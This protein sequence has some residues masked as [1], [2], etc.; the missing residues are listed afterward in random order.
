MTYKQRC[1]DM[2]HKTALRSLALL[3]VLATALCVAGCGVNQE[4]TE[5]DYE[6]F[7]N[8]TW[9]PV[10]VEEI[11]AIVT[12]D[13]IANL[14]KY[15]GLKKVDLSGSTCYA[16][17]LAYME[18]HPDVEVTYTVSLGGVFVSTQSTDLILLPGTYD[19][20][21]M[22]ENLAYLPEVTNI[23][24]QRTQL[25][26]EQMAALSEAYPEITVTYSIEFNGVEYGEGTTELNMADFDTAQLSTAM[27]K[28]AMM[29][30]ITYVE[31]MKED[32]T[33]NYTL[34]Q[35]KQL[36]KAAPHIAFN[37]NV[38]FFGKTVST[39]DDIVDF[40]DCDVDDE[41][42]LRSAMELLSSASKVR[43]IGSDLSH[44]TLAAIQ[45]DY[46][47]TKLVWRV[48][49]AGTP[50]LTDE[51]TLFMSQMSLRDSNVENLKYLTS[52]KYVDAGHSEKLTDISWLAYM[53]DVE[54]LILSGSPI[55]DISV[56][57]NCQKI[58]WLELTFCG[59]LKDISVVE[60][61]PTLKYLNIGYTDVS[62]ISALADLSLERFHALSTEVS[63]A[64][65]QAF[66]EA[67]PD[68]WTT[69][70]GS[71]QPYGKGWRY[72]DNGKTYFEY[73]AN[74]REIFDYASR[75]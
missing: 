24:L 72:D 57:S 31:L 49:V 29:D 2:T 28:L 60:N 62:D 36:Q 25:S 51:E 69:Y 27:E 42:E 18:S 70:Y 44:E 32:G 30:Q 41:D 1:T 38:A 43:V 65:F 47:N 53:P 22:M 12:E 19:F 34:D 10:S 64:D 46:P 45:A 63:N 20:D 71:K 59:L 35:L 74:M 67:H 48:Y 3:L 17:I 4:P 7:T 58:V 13:S 26:S 56:L 14:D 55:T 16:A 37:Y 66:I 73:Y 75:I 52:A 68:C 23:F 9:A 21:T 8:P 6:A 50:F 61:I 39:A 54:I 5:P 15:P 11:S 40:S 33:T